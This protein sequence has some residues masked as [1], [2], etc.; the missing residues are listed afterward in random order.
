MTRALGVRSLDWMHHRCCLPIG[1]VMSRP[2]VEGGHGACVM[3][4]PLMTRGASLTQRPVFTHVLLTLRCGCCVIRH[5]GTV[6]RRDYL[7]K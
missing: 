6:Q 7:C 4:H 3:R 5:A 1:C 2:R